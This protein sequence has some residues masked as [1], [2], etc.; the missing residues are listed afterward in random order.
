MEQIVRFQ[1]G[2]RDAASHWA[3]IYRG[4]AIA[5]GHWPFNRDLGRSVPVRPRPEVGLMRCE[6][7]L[8][9]GV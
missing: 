7:E 4:L 2:R 9:V 8:R 1:V 6:E 3:S 5:S